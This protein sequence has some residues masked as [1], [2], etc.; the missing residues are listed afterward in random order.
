MLCRGQLL[1]L[2]HHSQQTCILYYYY[3]HVVPAG[4]LRAIVTMVA[5]LT[6][7]K[8]HLS[9]CR[10]SQ[11]QAQL[12]WAFEDLKAGVEMPHSPVRERMKNAV[13]RESCLR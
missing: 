13:E 5:M 3:M 10:G 9:G 4:W 6:L 1:C 12:P 7:Q 11:R 8:S 2:A